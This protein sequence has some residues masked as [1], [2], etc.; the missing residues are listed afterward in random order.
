MFEEEADVVD[1]FMLNCKLGRD[2]D[3]RRAY[4][5]LERYPRNP[6]LWRMCGQL[7]EMSK[8]DTYQIDEARYCYEKTIDLKPNNYQGYED[9]GDWYG[10]RDDDYTTAI[11]YYRQ[12][13]ELGNK[14]SSRIELAHALARIGQKDHALNE[15]EF[16]A[17]KNDDD[18]ILMKKEILEG[19]LDPPSDI[20]G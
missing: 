11:E 16:C 20:A 1:E 6:A 10:V 18:Y 9:L 13:I 12:A 14:D 15:L 2:E 7:I 4:E 17:D 8:S 19:L 3:V 5:L